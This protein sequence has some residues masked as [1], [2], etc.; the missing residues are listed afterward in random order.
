MAVVLLGPTGDPIA[1]QRSAEELLAGH[2]LDQERRGLMA[3]T[4]SER[5]R[6]VRALIAWMS[7]RHVLDATAEDLQTF[8]DER[9]LGNT[10]RSD[11]VGI[12]RSFYT[13]AVK[14]GL[15]ANAPTD[16]IVAPR[17]RSGLPKPLTHAELARALDPSHFVDTYAH[18]RLRALLVLGAFAGLRAQ[19]MAGLAVED[20]DAVNGVLRVRRGKGGNQRVVPL[21]PD[22][23]AALQAL[24]LPE[25]GQVFVV[26][27]YAGNYRKGPAERL[28]DGEGPIN[29]WN[30]SQSVG[31]YLHS[32]GIDASCHCL[33]H[34]F[35]TN[36]YRSTQD[37]RL[38]Q[39]LLGHS[40]PAVTAIYAAADTTKA[41]PAVMALGVGSGTTGGTMTRTL[42]DHLGEQ[43]DGER[44]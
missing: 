28:R 44:R 34:T 10:A 22:V 11:Y 1:S 29:P 30:V 42:D 36:I 33:R 16:D 27:R 18:R 21:H 8:L 17:R 43:I 15:L 2:R 7:P 9:D 4:I 31:R 35:A 23:L 24:P 3:T 40:S 32:I 25:T 20:V 12:W 19:E 6:K 13:W 14:R 41:A 38:T 26:G 37:L 5:D 39:E